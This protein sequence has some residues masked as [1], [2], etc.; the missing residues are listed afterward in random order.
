MRLGKR[1][2]Y[3]AFF[4][5]K[6]T[7][8]WPEVA[9]MESIRSELSWTKSEKISEARRWAQFPSTRWNRYFKGR[10]VD[11]SG[12]RIK[13]HLEYSILRGER[14]RKLTFFPSIVVPSWGLSSN[15]ENRDWNAFKSFQLSTSSVN[16]RPCRMTVE[17]HWSHEISNWKM[18]REKCV[19]FRAQ[20]VFVFLISIIRWSGAIWHQFFSTSQTH[21]WLIS[22]DHQTFVSWFNKSFSL[23][24]GGRL[25]RYLGKEA[26]HHQRTAYSLQKFYVMKTRV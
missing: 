15:S 25:H 2:I 20:K 7:P 13:S 11:M 21:W 19:E 22:F 26:K 6:I 17:P 8:K 18:D 12:Y 4:A 14:S 9:T 1:I 24:D 5:S 16:S 23:A 10:E 3:N